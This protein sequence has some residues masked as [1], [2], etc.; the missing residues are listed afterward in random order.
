QNLSRR[1][2]LHIAPSPLSPSHRALR[3]STT[4]SYHHHRR[5]SGACSSRRDDGGAR[6]ASTL[7]PRLRPAASDPADAHPRPPRHR[8]PPRPRRPP[9]GR[10][11]RRILPRSI[12]PPFPFRLGNFH[13][14]CAPPV[15]GPL[16]FRSRSTPGSSVLLQVLRAHLCPFGAMVTPGSCPAAPTAA[17]P[18]PP[19]WDPPPPS[20]STCHRRRHRPLHRHRHRRP[21]Q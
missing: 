6:R 19:P 12:P 5:R 7:A 3:G 10:L 1:P 8:L 18:P 20:P 14:R 2:I 15:A 4:P 21:P 13:V 17:H 11:R 16:G 9:L